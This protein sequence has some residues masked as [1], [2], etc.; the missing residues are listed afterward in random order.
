LRIE[1]EPEVTVELHAVGL[2]TSVLTGTVVG[3]DGAPV[4]DA[5]VDVLRDSDPRPSKTS[6]DAAGKFRIERKGAALWLIGSS[7]DHAL[8]GRVR[9]EVEQDSITLTLAPVATVIG[10]LFEDQA[11]VAGAQ[12]VCDAPVQIIGP[13]GNRFSRSLQS[14]TTATAPDGRF[15]IP[16]LIVGERY[17]VR[18]D[19]GRP[20]STEIPPEG[21]F[22]SRV[23]DLPIA[24]VDRP[25]NID[26]GYV[27]L[28]LPRRVILMD[29]GTRFEIDFAELATSRFNDKADI[30][31]RLSAARDDAKREYRRVMLVVGDPKSHDT[32]SLTQFLFKLVEG[33]D[34]ADHVLAAQ[35]RKATLGEAAPE[36]TEEFTRL[37]TDFQRVHINVNDEPAAAHLARVYQVDVTKIALP[38]LMVLAEDGKLAAQQSFAGAGDPPQFDV[39]SLREFLKRHA[40]PPRN[41][42]ELMRGARRR[43][44]DENKRILLHHSSP[45][46][47]PCR[48]LTRFIERHLD[49]LERDYVY[50]NIDAYRSIKGTEV[51][52]QFR[53]PGGAVPWL[54]ILNSD[55]FKLADSDGPAGNIGFP[56]EPEAINY[57]IDQMLKPP[58]Q[59]LTAKDLEELRSALGNPE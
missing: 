59:R 20:S 2:E 18:V 52:E 55:G 56:S 53:K 35:Q 26:M 36:N 14:V 47:Y 24:E 25:G 48:L 32:Q 4:K 40:L 50:V 49:L 27:K 7:P 8:A 39:E 19:K 1:D 5:A 21:T 12:L 11:P 13:R 33:F 45:G 42:E 16:G 54:A 58:A 51:I 9:V 34:G 23:A 43:A 3:P 46:S 41:A 15:V 44:R 31:T 38:A 28:P 57:F 22:F 30:A 37:L 17:R 29:R 6:S 10:R